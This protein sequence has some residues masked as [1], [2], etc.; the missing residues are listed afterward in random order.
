MEMTILKLKK[1]KSIPKNFTGII[2]LENGTKSWYKEG[3]YHRLNGPAIE[4]SDGEK[5]W[6]K[7]GR[8][9]RLD[10][11]AIEYPDGR[12]YWFKEGK[13]HREDSPA[14][15]LPDGSKYWYIENILYTPKKLSE[16]IN[17]AFFLGKEKGQYNLEWIKFLT[18]EGIKE[19]PIISGME[20]DIEFKQI[21]DKLSL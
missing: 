3:E 6:F 15:E 12:K 1:D 14:I 20:L 18:E 8:Y 2:E 5:H 7:E 17:S 4:C 19:F 11:P 13:I 16:L 21:F 10:G 9:H